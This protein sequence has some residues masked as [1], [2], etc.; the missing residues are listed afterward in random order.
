MPA[1]T[2]V[3]T[4]SFLWNLARWNF[5]IVLLIAAPVAL[6][7]AQSST[8]AQ[9]PSS[10]T[11]PSAAAQ[12]QSSSDYTRREIQPDLSVDRDPVRSP[13]P[14]ANAAVL[15]ATPATATSVAKSSNIYTLHESVDEVLLNCTVLDEKGRVVTDLKPSN[16]RVWEDGAPQT[17]TSFQHEDAPVSMGILVDDSGS[18]RF[19][20]PA[21]QVAALDM[22]RESNP[23]DM[24]FIVNFS[25]RAWLDQ[26]FTSNLSALERGLSHYD[27]RGT[28]AIYDAVAASADQLSK[29]A[30]WPKQALLIITDGDDNASHLTLQHTVERVQALGGP[31]VYAIGMLYDAESPRE[32]ASAR[33]AL[34]TLADDTGG[35]AF[36]PGSVDEVDPI[37]RGVARDIR[38]QYTIGYHS[39]RSALV[40]G[41]RTVHVEAQAPGHGRLTVRT[42]HGYYPQQLR[43]MNSVVEAATDSHP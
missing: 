20:R 13:D 23:R 10:I 36:F 38:N 6:A 1:M 2:S 18:M 42:R 25:D 8:A 4:R 37:A 12:V 35:L 15:P 29:G 41:Y 40:G 26:G 43:Q 30:K 28:T 3:V 31:V 9:S 11:A 34:E 7:P 24:E 21:V 27:A 17:I 33:S 39:P 5:A 16:F 14:A 32:A 19:K 22:V